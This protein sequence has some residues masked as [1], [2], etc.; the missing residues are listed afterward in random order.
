MATLEKVRYEIQSIK[1]EGLREDLLG[2]VSH[3][4]EH[5]DM[6][7]GRIVIDSIDA[8]ISMSLNLKHTLTQEKVLPMILGIYEDMERYEVDKSLLK[9]RWYTHCICHNRKCK[10]QTGSWCGSD[11][12]GC[13]GG[14]MPA[15]GV[16]YF[17]EPQIVV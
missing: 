4:E 16:L 15:P 10:P 6:K 14:D 7:N 9:V 3:I 5:I 1:I 17:A 2:L 13:M 12:S 11:S 8:L